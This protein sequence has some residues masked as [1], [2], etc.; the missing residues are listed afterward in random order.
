MLSA[1]SAT[2]VAFAMAGV[3]QAVLATIWLL[4]AWLVGDTRHAAVYWAGYA[5]LSAVS[6]ALLTVALHSVPHAEVLRAAGNICAVGG[7]L[8]LQRG[9]WSFVGR[10]PRLVGHAGAFAVTIVASYVGLSPSGASLRVSITS[11]VLASLSIGMALDLHGHARNDL[12]F[13]WPWLFSLPLLAATV[14]FAFRGLRAWLSPGSVTTEMITD[15]ALNV[16]SAMGY[17]IIALTFH[18]TL[19]AM[20][21]GRLLT[22]LRYR[23][24][25]DVLT[26][27]LNR[28]AM[29]EVMSAQVRRSQRSGET[30]TVLMLDL[31]HFKAVNDRYGHAVGDRALKHAAAL[32]KASVR[33]VDGLARFGGEEFVALMPGAGID[34]A[35]GVAERIREQLAANPLPMGEACVALSISIGVAQWLSADDDASRLL[36]RA[37]TAL[38]QAKLQGRNRVVLA[39]D[40]A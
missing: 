3:M 37:D 2:D 32:L 22:E 33:Q 38:Y 8:A 4:G 36:V 1:M 30:F 26:G 15:S 7:L 18:A 5:G 12:Q 16:G 10:R 21:V 39:R 29:E 9:I 6:F 11:A 25:H 14:G 27:L 20:V 34:V 17:M 31:D 35:L 24:R 40:L 23:S 13:R 19:M 28:R